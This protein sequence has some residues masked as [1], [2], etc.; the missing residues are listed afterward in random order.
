MHSYKSQCCICTDMGE[1]QNL[2]LYSLISV[3][4]IPGHSRRAAC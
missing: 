3:M 4:P 1:D 2:V